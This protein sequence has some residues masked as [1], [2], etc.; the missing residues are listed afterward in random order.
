MIDD[1]GHVQQRGAGLVLEFAPERPRIAQPRQVLRLVVR[2][3]EVARGPVGR[4]VTVTR[5]ELLE[6]CHLPAGA[7]KLPRGGGTHRPAT[8]DGDVQPGRAH[9]GTEESGFSKHSEKE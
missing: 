3:V 9:A 1:S 8:D 5:L 4:A 7:G 2:H 6:Q